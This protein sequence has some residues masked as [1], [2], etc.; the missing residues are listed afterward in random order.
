[1]TNVLQ[2][3]NEGLYLNYRRKTGLCF[4][5]SDRR[6]IV[7]FQYCNTALPIGSNVYIIFF[8]FRHGGIIGED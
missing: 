3:E 2:W 7:D 6:K 5:D 8:D 4:P 1:V